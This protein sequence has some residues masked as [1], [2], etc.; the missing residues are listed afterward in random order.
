MNSDSVREAFEKW[1]A[2]KYGHDIELVRGARINDQCYDCI[3]PEDRLQNMWLSVKDFT[4][5]MQEEI[6][7]LK[8]QSNKLVHIG[9]TDGNSIKRSAKYH[10]RF[11][12]NHCSGMDIPVYMLEK[13][14]HR[15]GYEKYTQYHQLTNQV[16]QLQ[17]EVEALKEGQKWIDVNNEQPVIKRCEVAEVYG[18]IA[19]YGSVSNGVEEVVKFDGIEWYDMAGRT[20]TVTHWKPKSEPPKTQDN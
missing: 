15:L 1:Y 11:Y 10:G 5:S 16:E 6:D 14:M 3:D 19:P 18:W 17:A 12:L 8:S 20:C 13:H 4:A 9:F 7:R 2:D